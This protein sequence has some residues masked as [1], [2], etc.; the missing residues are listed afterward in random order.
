MSIILQEY[1][2]KPTLETIVLSIKMLNVAACTVMILVLMRF[3]LSLI[4]FLMR[5]IENPKYIP[6]TIERK[7]SKKEQI[8][9]YFSCLIMPLSF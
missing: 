9:E 2:P 5:K 7:E 4:I 6:V 8:T 3:S 1:K